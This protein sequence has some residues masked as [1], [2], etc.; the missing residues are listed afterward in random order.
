M[1]AILAKNVILGHVL[2]FFFKKR[3][4]PEKLPKNKE[5][6]FLENLLNPF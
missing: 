1:A 3:E 6:A 4:I 5:K 2:P